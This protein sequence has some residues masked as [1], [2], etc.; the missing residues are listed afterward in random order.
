MLNHDNAL[1]KNELEIFNLLKNIQK[2]KQLISVSFQSLPQYCLTSLMHVHYDA[3]VLVF[4]EPNPGLSETLLNTKKEAQF[5][6]K[7]DQL[8]IIFR[9]TL[10]SGN[11]KNK[12]ND[13]YTLFPDEIYYPQNRNFYRFNTEFMDDVNATIFLSSTRKLSCKLINISLNGLCLRFPYS[14]ASMFQVNQVIDDIYI[15]LPDHNGFS[16]SARVQNSRIEN[17]YSNIAIGLQIQQHRPIV[18]KTIQQFI[19]RSENI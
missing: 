3:K 15:E 13:L 4:D 18:E 2:S 19:F 16:I 7:L 12:Y 10:I 11:E 1:V 14:F 6:L 9:S 8:P 17:S 5:S